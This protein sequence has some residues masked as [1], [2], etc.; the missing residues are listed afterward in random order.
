MGQF[1]PEAHIHSKYTMPFQSIHD[2]ILVRAKTIQVRTLQFVIYIIDSSI[3]GLICNCI[4]YSYNSLESGVF[5]NLLLVVWPRWLFL[6]INIIL[7][8]RL[9]MQKIL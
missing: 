2:V 3:I 5:T 8:V 9:S 7:K 1:T 6:G 4:Y